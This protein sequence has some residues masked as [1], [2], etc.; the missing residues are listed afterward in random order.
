[1]SLQESVHLQFAPYYNNFR[2]R[3]SGNP[4]GEVV[5]GSSFMNLSDQ[6]RLASHSLNPTGSIA[7]LPH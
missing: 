4:F 3:Q 6:L 2:L 1:M 5:K 7:D